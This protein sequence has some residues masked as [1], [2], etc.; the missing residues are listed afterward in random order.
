MPQ[1]A[2]LCTGCGQSAGYGDVAGVDEVTAE[3]FDKM[4]A[5]NVRAPFLQLAS[6]SL[7]AVVTAARGWAAALAERNIRVNGSSP[8]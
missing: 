6:L 5:T 1:S 2:A 3:F 7:G 8:A 4:I